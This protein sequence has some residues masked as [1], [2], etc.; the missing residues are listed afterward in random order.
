M[1]ETQAQRLKEVRVRGTRKQTALVSGRA[2]W[3]WKDLAAVIGVAVC[4]ADD[5]DAGEDVLLKPFQPEINRPFVRRMREFHTCTGAISKEGES[6]TS[7]AVMQN[8]PNA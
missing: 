4:A 3:R 5:R 1:A 7:Q 6:I 8:P 2:G